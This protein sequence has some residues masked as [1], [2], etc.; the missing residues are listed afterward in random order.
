MCVCNNEREREREREKERERERGDEKKYKS[1][2]P[3]KYMYF[4][5]KK[6]IFIIK[7]PHNTQVEAHVYALVIKKK[8]LAS[9]DH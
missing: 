6:S 3:Y 8:I 4:A 7:K 1:W 5:S 2:L 9:S